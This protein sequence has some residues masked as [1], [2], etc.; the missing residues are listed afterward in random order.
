M[1]GLIIVLFLLFVAILFAAPLDCADPLN[2]KSRS[3]G[4]QVFPSRDYPMGTD[5]IGH[6]YLSRVIYGIRTSYM[7]GF[8]PGGS[9]LP[10]S[11]GFRWGS[12]L[13][14]AVGRPTSW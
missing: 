6:N 13:G 4:G 8:P 14:C 11:S 1:V 9:S 10:V 12:Q 7:V 5:Q 3:D 2:T